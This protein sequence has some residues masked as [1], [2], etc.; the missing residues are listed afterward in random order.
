[1]L[2]ITHFNP[3]ESINALI[4]PLGFVVSNKQQIIAKI[5]LLALA[6]LTFTQALP[7]AE[8]AANNYETA[9][10]RCI[11]HSKAGL[12]NVCGA[13]YSS[14]CTLKCAE[15]TFNRTEIVNNTVKVISLSPIT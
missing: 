5:T 9:L 3:I 6:V 8:R 2:T 4:Q 7:L 12:V 1:M 14:P 11:E 10:N 15:L 13:N